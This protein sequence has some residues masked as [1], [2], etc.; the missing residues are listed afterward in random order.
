MATLREAF[1]LYDKLVLK[2]KSNRERQTELG[3][4]KIHIDPLLGSL[5]C[6]RIKTL[7]I[8]QL[9]IS[10]SEKNLS[11]QTVY[12][13]LSL[14]RRVLNRAK[15]LELF[16]GQLPKFRMPKFDNKR[17]RIL[18]KDEEFALLLE[19][20]KRS[21]LWHDISILALNTGLRAGE[22]YELHR[23]NIDLQNKTVKIYDAKNSSNRIIPLNTTAFSIIKKYN[24]LENGNDKIFYF[25][26]LSPSATSRYFRDAVKAC[27]FNDSIGDRRE[28]VCF[29]TLRHTFASRLVAENVSLPVVAKILG[30]KTI[31]MTM[32]YTHINALQEREAVEI[33]EK[34]EK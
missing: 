7:D 16:S 24:E 2:T 32:R 3:R 5:Q 8:E 26:K 4:W 14:V 23:Y 34:N 29:H 27:K 12:H 25:N 17:M 21:E 10:V 9:K 11:P 13:C 18:T 6:D 30:H 33:L 15:E 22:I 20:K 28:K 31:K 1:E 19:L